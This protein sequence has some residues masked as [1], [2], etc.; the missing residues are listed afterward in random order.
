MSSGE[1]YEAT[2]KAVIIGNTFTRLL[3]PITL[4]L[5]P[6]LLPICGIPLIEYYIDA[7]VSSN[8]KEIIIC[9]KDH[10]EELKAYIA[11]CNKTHLIKIFFNP[12]F[13]SEGDC[14]RKVESAKLI[15]NDFILIR[16]LLVTNIDLEKAYTIHLSNK[17][18]DK[19]CIMTSLFKKYKNEANWKTD[20]DDSVI[21]Y[22]KTTHKIYQYETTFDKSSIKFN[23]NLVFKPSKEGVY[24]SYV[25]RSDLYDACIHICSPSVL[26]MFHDNFDYHNFRDDFYGNML[27][28]EIYFDTFYMYEIDR[29]EYLALIRNHE[30][31]LKCNFEVINKWAHPVVIE[32]VLSSPELNIN[33]KPISFNIYS[34]KENSEQNFSEAKLITSIVISKKCY[35][36]KDSELTRVVLCNDVKIGKDCKITNCIIFNGCTIGN[37]VTI[38]NSILCEGVNIKDGLVIE[39]SFIGKNIEQE[40]NSY[41]E[42]I[43]TTLD[44]E[45]NESILECVD[46]ETFFKN[47][48][49]KEFIYL[50]KNNTFTSQ[51][52]SN[53][54]E[55]T[56]HD[57]V[58]DSED[59][60]DD[61][62]D[63]EEEEY[64]HVLEAVIETGITK[65]E[66]VN[67]IMK[68]ISSLKSAYWEKTYEETM[69]ACLMPIVRDF[70]HDEHFTMNHIQ[71]LRELLVKWKPLFKR[72]VVNDDVEVNLIGVIEYV[73]MEITEMSEGFNIF[74]QVLNSDEMGVLKDKNIKTWAAR[75]ESWFPNSEGNVDIPEDVHKLNLSKM[76][77]YLETLK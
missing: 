40:A 46:K 58:T 32:N 45:T 60:L 48:E 51:K 15:K 47:L 64:E 68:E 66:N 3:D 69:K 62:E 73:C 44:D 53:E 74:I 22:N 19:N 8:V 65:K 59:D 21:I 57:E 70:L 55:L 31:Y 25:V 42:R 1:T 13:T 33:Y 6:L 23:D 39:E 38:K 71:P 54:G 28:N 24:P 16:G 63:E 49:E 2:R 56:E 17:K 76:Q 67:D 36:G 11:S 20:Y 77:K 35:I 10:Y 52:Q 26:G 12:N 41:Q 61:D 72:M 7:L 4:D 50:C 27:V 37:G 75:E 18:H 5:P 43:F 34:D 14:L 29:G 9:I 30:S